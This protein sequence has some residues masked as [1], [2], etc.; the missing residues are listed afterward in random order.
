MSEQTI[1]DIV[2]T[3]N[4]T[5]GDAQNAPPV[6]EE[7]SAVANSDNKTNESK[8]TVEVNAGA[9]KKKRTA[10]RQMTKDDCDDDDNAGSN[11]GDGVGENTLR[12]GFQRASEEVLAKRRIIKVSRP[13]TGSSSGNGSG[14]GGNVF[15]NASFGTGAKNDVDTTK[16]SNTDSS[17]SAVDN[18]ADTGKKPKAFGSTTGFA[19]F[20]TAATSAGGGFGSVGGG[21]CSSTNSGFTNNGT[22]G[23]GTTG[24]SSFGGGF[25]FGRNSS[26]TT[27]GFGSLS[28]SRD[29]ND[30]DE[31]TT[32]S[33]FGSDPP[34]AKS[35]AP[36][37]G[38]DDDETSEG[39]KGETPDDVPGG[40]TMTPV[41]VFPENVNLKT[42][43]EGERILYE[44]R[45]KSYAQV[46]VEDKNDDNDDN[47]NV[48]DDDHKAEK[49]NPSVKP[50][51]TFQAIS[52]TP[53]S[54]E[55]DTE[56]ADND[57]KNAAEKKPASKEEGEEEAKDDSKPKPNAGKIAASASGGWRWQEKGIGPIK[58]LQD[59]EHPDKFRVVHRQEGFKDGPG[60]ALLLNRSLW[61][62]ST[63]THMDD[64]HTHKTCLIKGPK[65]G[66]GVELFSFKFGDST[67]CGMFVMKVNEVISKARSAF[68]A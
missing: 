60:H 59:E 22:T 39:S 55:A 36:D 28:T 53:S 31:S 3:A 14:G 29:A 15:G 17:A 12:Q 38:K 54:D 65:E 50:S 5:D 62:E 37:S 45:C 6:L 25:A 27:N 13:A 51:T 21:F 33:P 24:S 48:G 64:A 43:E 49:I 7:A 46:P 61:K 4:K 23:F 56:T 66:G 19:G 52:K 57:D 20:K 44:G 11:G 35:L 9:A 16:S 2:D 10:E 26:G 58:I 40:P 34:A 32:K 30:K 8:V 1:D 68:G 63:C 42:G 41:A 47:N 18:A 67:K